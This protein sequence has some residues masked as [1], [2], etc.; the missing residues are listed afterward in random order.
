MK[1]QTHFLCVNFEP[2]GCEDNCHLWRQG[3][4]KEVCLQ[5]YTNNDQQT[6]FIIYI[7]LKSIFLNK[8]CLNQHCTREKTTHDLQKIW[9]LKTLPYNVVL[10]TFGWS[11]K[12]HHMLSLC[13]FKVLSKTRLLTNKKPP[14]TNIFQLLC[15]FLIDKLVLIRRWLWNKNTDPRSL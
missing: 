9:V 4:K 13:G 1:T 11:W 5:P 3:H 15:T 6:A 12:E 14:K 2:G 8:V 7:C 10:Y